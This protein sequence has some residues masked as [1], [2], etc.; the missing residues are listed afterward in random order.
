MTRH[1]L[2]EIVQGLRW[3]R[4]LGGAL[5]CPQGDCPI[6]AAYRIQFPLYTPL[7]NRDW[8]M[9]AKALGLDWETARSLQIEADWPGPQPLDV[10]LFQA[11]V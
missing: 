10:E 1:E 4:P 2:V 6:L 5:R 8:R 11:A 9:A 7:R 3:R